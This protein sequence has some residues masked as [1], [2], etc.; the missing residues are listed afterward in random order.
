M[1]FDSLS[2]LIHQEL[3]GMPAAGQI[4]L[5]TNRRKNRIKLLCHD[6]S[7]PILITKR[8]KSGRPFAIALPGIAFDA[9]EL[10]AMLDTVETTTANDRKPRWQQFGQRKEAAAEIQAGRSG[11]PGGAN[12]HQTRERGAGARTGSI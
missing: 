12:W 3:G 5:F 10:R 1:S 7:G 4:F 9:D 2:S 8:G 11:S 6:N